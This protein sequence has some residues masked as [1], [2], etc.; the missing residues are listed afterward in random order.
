MR[1][2]EVWRYEPV[3]NRQ[4]QST[5]RLIV[6][7]NGINDAES[8]PIVFGVH[9]LDSDPGQLLAVHVAPWGWAS[10]LTLERVMRRR[11][12]EQLA[13]V[14]DDVLEQV[15]ASLLAALEL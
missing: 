10:A 8:L 13:T 2:G 15:D 6:S 14:P 1:R 12:V 3:M 7:A 11:L 9:V 4:G 5:V